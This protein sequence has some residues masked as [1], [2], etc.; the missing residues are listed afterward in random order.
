MVQT[1]RW[2]NKINI[3]YY[4]VIRVEEGSK[5]I[6]HLNCEL[7]WLRTKETKWENNVELKA[8]PEAQ[9]L[10]ELLNSPTC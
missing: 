6:A 7:K 10:N 8:I 3:N 5:P 4:Q 9:I 1:K 2:Q